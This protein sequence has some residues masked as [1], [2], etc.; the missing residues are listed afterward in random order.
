MQ[1]TARQTQVV[2][3]AKAQIPKLRFEQT[4]TLTD[5]KQLIGVSV[6]EVDRVFHVGSEHREHQVVVFE[7]G[8]AHVQRRT[9]GTPL[10]G[11]KMVTFQGTLRGPGEQRPAM[12]C[13]YGLGFVRSSLVVHDAVRAV[14]TGARDALLVAQRSRAGVKRRV[15]LGRQFAEASPLQHQTFPSEVT[16]VSLCSRSILSNSARKFPAPKPLSP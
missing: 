9:A 16:R 11:T 8:L 15:R 6:D 3:R 10:E 5:E 4:A 12:R 2:V 14:E 7:Q 1:E 13:V